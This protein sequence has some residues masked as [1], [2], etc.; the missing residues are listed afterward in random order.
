MLVPAYF[1]KPLTWSPT[2]SFF[3]LSPVVSF[4]GNFSLFKSFYLYV[5]LQGEGVA[6]RG[7]LLMAVQAEFGESASESGI[8]QVE[9]EP[10]A[11]ISDV[12]RFLYTLCVI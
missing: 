8:R 6:Y 1:V 7:R 9:V 11:P 3:D 4:S 12:R 10:T 2:F 5:F